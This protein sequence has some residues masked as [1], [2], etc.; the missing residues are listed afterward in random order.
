MAG[1]TPAPLAHCP[2]IPDPLA[3]VPA[4]DTSGCSAYPSNYSNGNFSLQ[5]GVYCGGLQA[6]THANLT[7]A[8]GVYVIRNGPLQVQ[9]GAS[10]TGIGVTFY[11][12]GSNV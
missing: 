4:P 2:D 3:D 7:L 11:L 10:I 12:S 9:A 8:P 1:L 6:L 5:P